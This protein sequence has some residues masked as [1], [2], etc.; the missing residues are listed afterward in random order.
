MRFP[1]QRIQRFM[2]IRKGEDVLFSYREFLSSIGD[3]T[4]GSRE[5]D[6]LRSPWRIC[7]CP[8]LTKQMENDWLYC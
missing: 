5:L 4:E 6:C 8:S 7:E 1:P 3:G 2:E